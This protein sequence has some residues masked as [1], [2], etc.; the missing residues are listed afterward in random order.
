MREED[1]ANRVRSPIFWVILVLGIAV[2]IISFLLLVMMKGFNTVSIEV[3]GLTYY[4]QDDFLEKISSQTA[5]KNTLVFRAEQLYKGQPRIPYIEK[6]DVTIAEN[7]KIKIQVY[8]KILV[9]CVK[10]MGQYMFFDKDGYVTDSGPVMLEG[11]PEI[12]GL[13]FDRIVLYEKLDLEKNRLFSVILDL[14]KLINDYSLPVDT[15]LFD[16]RGNVEIDIDQLTINLGK[17]DA[18]DKQIQLLNSIL[19]EVTGRA[20]I[21]DLSKYDEEKTIYRMTPKDE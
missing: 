12:K 14:K 8:Q 5:R 13:E 10:V 11:V 19:P 16:T 6:Y 21:I 7:H 20:L 3:N 15:I 9:G 1:N 2:I 4:T 18:Y 17:S